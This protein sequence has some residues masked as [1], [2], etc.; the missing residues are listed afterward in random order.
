MK[1]YLTLF[2]LTLALAAG[3]T[4]GVADDQT[5]E[6]T[7]NVNSNGAGYTAMLQTSDFGAI[8]HSCN[9]SGTTS[10]CTVKDQQ[11]SIPK[12][13][14]NML[15]VPGNVTYTTT[16]TC[17]SLLDQGKSSCQK[18]SISHQVC[19]TSQT[20]GPYCNWM[21]SSTAS[22]TASWTWNVTSTASNAITV[23]CSNS[24]YTATSP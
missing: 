19:D 20:I 3:A 8:L 13:M 2:I 15:C 17:Q 7:V 22:T 10:T 23:D 18:N 9:T 14:G 4:R 5:T 21:T 16:A 11:S 6:A 24:G 12:N 1:P